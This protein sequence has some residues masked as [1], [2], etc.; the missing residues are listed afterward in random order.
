MST[1]GRKF[2]KN[3][4]AAIMVSALAACATGARSGA[5]TAP[6]DTAHLIDT[7]SPFYQSMSV[8]SVEGG[9]KTNPLLQSKVANEDFKAALEQSL[10]L[11]TML[12]DTNG[13]YNIAVTIIDLKQ[14]TIGLGMTVTATVHYIVTPK[15]GGSAV[16][17]QYLTSPYTAKFSDA[18]V[19]VERLRLANEGAVRTSISQFIAALAQTKIAA[20]PAA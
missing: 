10:K 18:F 15:A 6:L 17:D 8:G 4:L 20:A 3:V 9:E 16:F 5:M 1:Q 12:A 19:G 14:P 11:N 7:T 13:K 2:L